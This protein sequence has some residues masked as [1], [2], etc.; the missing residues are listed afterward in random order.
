MN[1]RPQVRSIIANDYRQKCW[2]Y[3]HWTIGTD[4]HVIFHEGYSGEE[5]TPVVIAEDIEM[6]DFFVFETWEAAYMAFV[7]EEVS[8]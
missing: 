1:Q 8:D 5:M 3:S 7:L 4:R 6:R 2:D